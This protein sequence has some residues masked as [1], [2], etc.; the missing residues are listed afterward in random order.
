MILQSSVGGGMRDAGTLMAQLSYAP[1]GTQA[2]CI[3][4]DQR[5]PRLQ[6]VLA[7]GPEGRQLRLSTT[8]HPAAGLAVDLETSVASSGAWSSA[9]ATARWEAADFWAEGAL[10]L[11]LERGAPQATLAYH[12]SLGAGTGCTAGGTLQALLHPPAGGGALPDLLPP[13]AQ[14]LFWGTY[15]SWTSASRN[16]AAFVRY[17]QQPRSDGPPLE[18]TSLSFWRRVN[19]G[20]ELGADASCANAGPF[21]QPVQSG[22]GVGMRVTFQGPGTVQGLAPVLTAHA[23]TDMVVGVSL[24]VPSAAPASNTFMRTT[25]TT[26]LDHRNRDYKAGASVEMY[27]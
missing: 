20:L 3:V 7:P 26:V 15:G 25:L 23:S 16:S 10:T 21:T 9:K 14:Q 8:A 11:P 1:T 24:Q 19:K 5:G 13:R 22:A 4:G 18:A 17:A 6:A 12:Q 27:Y 2:V